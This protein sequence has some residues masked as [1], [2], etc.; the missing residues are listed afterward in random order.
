L[1]RAGFSPDLNWPAPPPADYYKI[2]L[3][4]RLGDLL[5][6]RRQETLVIEDQV[7]AGRP[8]A[9]LVNVVSEWS[10]P[11]HLR[12]C[13][14]PE[15]QDDLLGPLLHTAVKRLARFRGGRV[16]FNYPATTSTAETLIG[17]TGFQPRR[18]LTVMRKN[19]GQSPGTKG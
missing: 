9:G 6:G 18:T 14:A 11:H 15:R 12:L 7:D 17:S 1:D 19:L 3:W 5:N 13:I 4:Q 8:L 2:G 10:R 16:L